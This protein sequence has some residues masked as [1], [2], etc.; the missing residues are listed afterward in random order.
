MA[1][2]DIARKK[3][4][5]LEY[6]EDKHVLLIDK[7]RIY[8]K[9]DKDYWLFP[10]IVKRICLNLQLTIPEGCIGLLVKS[11]FLSAKIQ[12]DTKVIHDTDGVALVLFVEMVNRS[13]LPKKLSDENIIAELLVMPKTECHIVN[14]KGQS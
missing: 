7:T 3:E 8:I 9:P 2:L 14:T 1:S 6:E 5:V 10:G 11:N 4:P 13:L 12:F